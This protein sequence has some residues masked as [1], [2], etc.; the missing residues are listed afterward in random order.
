[1]ACEQ[2]AIAVFMEYSFKNENQQHQKRL[3]ELTVLKRADFLLENEEASEKYCQKELNGLVK[4]LR[5]SVSAGTFSMAGGHRLYMDMRAKIENDYWRVSRK[6]VKARGKQ[7]QLLPSHSPHSF[8]RE[9]DAINSG[10]VP[11]LDDAV[12]TLA[13]RENS[14]SVQ[15][16]VEH[17]SEQMAQRL[18]LPTDILQEL[19]GVHMAC[20]QEA[21]AVFLAVNK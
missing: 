20:E 19:L 15:R 9:V 3:L 11:C 16:A 2:E 10:A 21:I 18:R 1:M 6:G 12:T 17:Y 5:E 4:A 7:L 13:Q 8:V 14:A